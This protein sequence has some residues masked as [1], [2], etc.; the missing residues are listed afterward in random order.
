MPELH[1]QG[2]GKR[3]GHHTVLR[4][5]DL[6]L[7]HGERVLLGGPNGSGKTTLLRLAAGLLRPTEGRVERHGHPTTDA[8]GRVGLAYVGQDNPVYPELSVHEHLRWWQRL[9]GLHSDPSPLHDAGLQHIAEEPAGSLSR[10]QRQ[11]LHIAMAL[12]TAPS[13]L[14]LDE[15]TSALDADGRAWLQ[16]ALV[17]S[18]AAMLIASHDAL[19][20]L[21]ATARRLEDGC[22]S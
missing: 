1:C 12:A 5:I 19:S 16:Q 10:G 15:P 6:R 21:G 2:L 11:R 20:A 9:H 8:F 14:L 17:D 4:G 22:L 3:F 18:D 13:L 7:E